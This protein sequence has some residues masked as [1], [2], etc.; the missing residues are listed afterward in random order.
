VLG[1]AVA[2]CSLYKTAGQSEPRRSHR[3][4]DDRDFSV[5]KKPL[6]SYTVQGPLL[7][8]ALGLVISAFSKNGNMLLSSIRR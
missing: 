2:V 5:H 1:M 7:L 8:R 6:E 3:G 4:Q